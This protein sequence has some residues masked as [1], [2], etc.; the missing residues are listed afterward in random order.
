[1]NIK[2]LEK[3]A[4]GQLVCGIIIQQYKCATQEKYHIGNSAWLKKI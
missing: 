3:F 1:M 2:M 4:G